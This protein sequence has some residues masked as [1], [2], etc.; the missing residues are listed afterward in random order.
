MIF[1]HPKWVEFERLQ[2]EMASAIENGLTLNVCNPEWFEFG[3][4]LTHNGLSLIVCN[5][6]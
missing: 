3:T 4:S 6:K 1:C 2:T 5:T